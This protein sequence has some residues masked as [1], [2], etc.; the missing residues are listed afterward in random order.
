MRHASLSG[1][2][3]GDGAAGGLHAV[4]VEHGG[5]IAGIVD[6]AKLDEP[7]FI[8]FEHG[9][10]FVLALLFGPGSAIWE[11]E[12]VGDEGAEPLGFGEIVGAAIKDFGAA[13]FAI[14][15]VAVNGDHHVAFVGARDVVA[16]L[17]GGGILS[18]AA[19]ADDGVTGGAENVAETV[20]VIEGDGGFSMFDAIQ[21]ADGPGVVFESLSIGHAVAWIYA[22]GKRGWKGHG[23][24]MVSKPGGAGNDETRMRNEE[25]KTK[26]PL[27]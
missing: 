17:D 24:G 15:A 1:E 20:G 10:R 23:G 13:S 27:R 5:E 22:N 2:G 26:R 7:A 19:G 18:I 9:E 14:G 12:G 4:G 8:E 6:E 16:A 21:D 25:W 3:G 11:G